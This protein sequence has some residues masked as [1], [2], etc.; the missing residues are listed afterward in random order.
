MDHPLTVEDALKVRFRLVYAKLSKPYMGTAAQGLIV[1]DPRKG[2]PVR[3]LLHEMIHVA[4]PMYSEWKTQQEERR[5]WGLT[6]WQQKGELHRL[7][8]RGKV[9]NGNHDFDQ[10][11]DGGQP[12]LNE[13]EAEVHD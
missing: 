1:I 6:T 13:A 2:S 10:E 3:T 5:L 7:L 9:W 11:D 4:R 12:P 8:G